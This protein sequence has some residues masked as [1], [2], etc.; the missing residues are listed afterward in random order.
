MVIWRAHEHQI[1]S[2]HN[3]TQ[4]TFTRIPYCMTLLKLTYKT[5]KCIIIPCKC[6]GIIHLSHMRLIY[7]RI[8]LCMVNLHKYVDFI[9]N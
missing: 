8:L 7:E 3:T 6:L 1:S 4:N 5:Q 9:Q 2:T